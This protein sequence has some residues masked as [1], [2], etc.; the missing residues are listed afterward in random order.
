MNRYTAFL[1][2]VDARQ[3]PTQM[4]AYIEKKHYHV[5]KK[6]ADVGFV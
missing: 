4:P 5:G 6:I 3:L 1:T 2:H